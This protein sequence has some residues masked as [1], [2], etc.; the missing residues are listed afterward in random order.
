MESECTGNKEALVGAADKPQ[1]MGPGFPGQALFVHQSLASHEILTYE[2]AF[3]HVVVF[4]LCKGK[5]W[6]I[7]ALYLP[8]GTSRRGDHKAI[9][10]HLRCHIVATMKDEDPLLTLIRDFNIYEQEIETLLTTT[11]WRSL[12]LSHLRDPTNN[13][14]CMNNHQTDHSLDHF[15]VS[16]AVIHLS[17]E[18]S[19]IQD[20][21]ASYHCPVLLQLQQHVYLTSPPSI[22][23]NTKILQGHGDDLELPDR[24]NILQVDEINSQDYLDISDNKYIEILNN[25]GDSL[26]I[27]G[28]SKE[29]FPRYFRKATL[30]AIK[31]ERGLK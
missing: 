24:W 1:P 3:I 15:V 10:A 31:K 5:P 8:S 27:R 30:N 6:H 9:L 22:K 28:E 13:L 7:L 25:V 18:V 2:H 23:W 29:S 12:P 19:I 21:S 11:S 20:V 14:T 17:K 16:K 26:G 4:E